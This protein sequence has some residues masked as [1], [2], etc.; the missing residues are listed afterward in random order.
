VT[1]E[2]AD[3]TET[4]AALDLLEKQVS[5]DDSAATAE[6]TTPPA[7]E[8][9]GSAKINATEGPEANQNSDIMKDE[10]LDPELGRIKK[11]KEN[12]K[13]RRLQKKS[14]DEIEE[15]LLGILGNGAYVQKAE[16]SLL[17]ADFKIIRLNEVIEQGLRQGHEEQL[18]QLQGQYLDMQWDNNFETFWLP[19]VKL[20]L[21][22]AEQRVARVRKGSKSGHSYAD[23]ASGVLALELGEYTVFN[24]GKDYL[25]YLNNETN[26][27]RNKDTLYEKRR[28][29]KQDLIVQYF[30]LEEAKELETAFRQQLR[31]ASFIYRLNRERMAI[32]KA[33]KQEYFQ[34]RGDYLRAQQEYFQARI[35]VQLADER[36]SY[37]LSDP[38]GTRYIL[39]DKMKYQE[40]N[41]DLN[42]AIRIAQKNNP[43]V[44]DAVRDM[45]TTSRDYEIAIKDNLPLPKFTI[46]LGTYANTFSRNHNRTIYETHAED[47][48]LDIVASINATWA[49]TGE[50]GLF[51]S[52]KQSM[53]SL[54]RN[55]AVE[56]F[57]HSKDL[58]SSNIREIY[59]NLIHLQ[60]QNNI[61][62]S[63]LE[64]VR[65]TFDMI[66][67]NYIN[68][69]TTFINYKD[70]LVDRTQ[71][72]IE[73]LKNKL[74]HLKNKILLSQIM[75]VENPPGEI[76]E[77]LVLEE[78]LK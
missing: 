28:Q 15:D 52:R 58:A 48:N 46:N 49:L 11:E 26:Y 29:L 35:D 37:Y 1:P 43:S 7:E 71:T 39:K 41:L 67:D 59:K 66:V 40:I 57:N 33:T 60:N 61:L 14:K 2:N 54:K 73:F 74:T 21:V 22:T 25:Q 27:L 13:Q 51:N 19:Q 77:K 38:A 30:T 36:M 78:K 17:K 9:P 6:N 42:E 32:G 53:S 23:Q 75:G 56:T 72:E 8:T 4:A 68:R 44:L 24:W 47:S 69:K 45:Q 34:A 10:E 63:K 70:A 16:S 55:M 50:G 31:Q 64:V 76:L 20:S 65:K 62:T 12:F 5:T 3:T 18:R